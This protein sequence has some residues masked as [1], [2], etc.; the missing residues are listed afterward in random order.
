MKSTLIKA[1]LG[2]LALGLVTAHAQAGW[3]HDG[4]NLKHAYLQS[5]TYARHVDARQK[6]QMKRIQHG[7]QSGF[8]TRVEFRELM[9]AQRKIQTME[10]RFRAD[11]LIDTREFRHLDRALDRASHT[12]KVKSHGHQARHAYGSGYRIN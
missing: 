2:M 8:L 9:Q 4:Q 11:G 6:Q 3:E 12:I 1:G 5:Q 10:Q 7:R